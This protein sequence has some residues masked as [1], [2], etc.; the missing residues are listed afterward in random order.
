MMLVI[1][2]E[3]LP[4][5]PGTALSE[6]PSPVGCWSVIIFDGLFA[7]HVKPDPDH[8][9]AAIKVEVLKAHV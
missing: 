6:T 3:R 8:C 7:G 9:V 4:H 5:D 1:T 2:A